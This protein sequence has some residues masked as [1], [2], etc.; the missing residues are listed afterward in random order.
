M[1]RSLVAAVAGREGCALGA[2]VARPGSGAV[3]ADAGVLAGT[4]AS[5]IV[6]VDDLAR[7]IEAVDVVVDFTTP[8]ATCAH[9]RVAA[10][11][12]RAL[13]VG[14]TGLDEAQRGV[15]EDAAARVPVVWAPN[16]SVGVNLA[17]RLLAQAAAVLGDEADVEIVEMHHRHKADAPSGTALRMGEVLAATLG[18]DLDAVAEHGRHGRTGERSRRSIGFHALRGGD[19]VGE[20]TVVFAADGERLEITHRASD[21]TTF[22]AGAVRAAHWA[23]GR[24][25]GLYGMDDVL[26]S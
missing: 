3:G 16:F 2:A 24:A 4:E 11:A 21:R 14:T 20:H 23:A 25:P 22:A 6:V 15:L 8:E 12:G 19:V 5:G 18:R 10:A 9:A 26:V 17:L 7:V 1:G 13:V